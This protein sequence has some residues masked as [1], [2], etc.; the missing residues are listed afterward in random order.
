MYKIYADNTLFFDDTL[1]SQP[2]LQ[3]LDVKLTQEVNKA[4]CLEFTIPPQNVAY[5]LLQ[6]LKTTIVILYNNSPYIY[7]EGRVLHDEKDFWNRKKV[8]CE[9][10]LSYLTDA[11]VR[12]YSWQGTLQGY[13]YYLIRQQRDYVEANRSIGYGGGD[14]EDPNQYIV[15]SNSNYANV[16]D[17]MSSKI[18]NKV[19]GY[20]KLTLG[21]F[22]GDRRKYLSLNT[23]AGGISDQV[24]KFGKNL[25]DINEY[26]T[27]ENLF[28]VLIPL[29]AREET[30]DGSEGKRLTIKSVNGDLDYLEN[31]T[32]IN[33]FGRIIRFNEWDDVTV[34]SNLKTKGITFLNENISMSI[35]LSIDAVDLHYLDVNT[36]HITVGSQVRVVSEPHGLDT[37]FLCS[38]VVTDMLNPD[39]TEFV[40]GT[41]FNALTDKQIEASKKTNSAFETAESASSA[42][43]N[44]NT[45]VVGNYVSKSEFTSF[46]SQV[47]SNFTAVNN[48]LTNAMHYK[49]SVASETNL[50]ATGNSVGDVWD[51]QDTGADYVWTG[52]AWEKLSEDLT[53]Y[54]LK[55]AFDALEARVQA[56]EN[57]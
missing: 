7:W 53:L 33:L 55:T 1:Q 16:W 18:L 40:L 28:T 48:K 46:Q 3:L 30:Q 12:P 50:P 26:V 11:V 10:A 27:A 35:T 56:L 43:S 36:E 8:Y 19:G 29:G 52:S 57:N 34:A 14:V 13:F 23:S 37:Y 38:K 32:A 51:V 31:Q 22:G 45:S 5:S 15:R 42:I 24:I 44:I 49:G 17:E 4:G 41:G 25:L 20:L 54:V 9:G 6:K 21:I 2:E 39:R 47:N